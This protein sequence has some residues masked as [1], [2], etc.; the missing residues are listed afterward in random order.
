MKLSEGF[1]TIFSIC[2]SATLLMALGCCTRACE[3][4]EQNFEACFDKHPP[5]ECA[6]ARKVRGE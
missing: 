3:V 4:R 5:I 2:V 1:W 6:A